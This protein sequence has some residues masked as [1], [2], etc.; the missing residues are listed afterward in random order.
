MIDE[1]SFGR[2]VI[3]GKTYRQDVIV[4]PDRVKPNWWRREGH[5]LCL[6]DLEEV[7]RDPPEVLVIGTGYVGLMRVPREVREKL[8]EMGIQVVVEKTGKAY[9]TF[10][11]LLSEGRRV[12]AALHLTC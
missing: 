11:K 10:N 5:S 3:D 4:Y 12:V 7:L 8:E 6:E 2:I 1:Y 9:R